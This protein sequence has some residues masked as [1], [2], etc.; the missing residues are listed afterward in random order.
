MRILFAISSLSLGGSERVALSLCNHWSNRSHQ[1]TLVTVASTESD[2]YSAEPQITRIALG[3]DRASPN[4][5][6]FLRNN[7]RRIGSL[8]SVISS[9]AP[10]V[11][12]SFGDTTNVLAILAG[13]GRG[14]PLIVS[15]RTDPRAR[16]VGRVVRLL[17]PMLYRRARAV[18]VQ[19]NSCAD[20]ARS[21]VPHQV[22]HVIPN[23][24]FALGLSVFNR[25]ATRERR[26]VLTLGRMNSEKGFDLLL[27]AFARCAQ[28]HQQW[29]LRIVGDGPER[30][31]LRILAEDLRI[32]KRTRLDG[33]TQSPLTPLREAALF[34]LPSRREGFP[35]VLL[36]AMACG[37]P[38]VSFDCLSGPNEIITH[39]QNG[40]LAPAG[41]VEGLA[42][43]M[44]RLMSSESLREQ[45]AANA[46]E[47]VDRYSPKRI[48]GMWDSL[49]AGVTEQNPV[50]IR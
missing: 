24:V 34:V 8:R 11:A 16:E 1:V 33:P 27:R 3:L 10:D 22:V 9:V 15:E 17:R 40:L 13:L 43:A 28:R 21:I 4:T 42:A 46:V 7:A 50:A 30:P 18:V 31:R 12:V 32:A 23:P 44:D 49:V 2:F 48:F 37:L 25:A 6:Q 20:W 29:D 41:D 26:T 35:N 38:V 45:L 47:V 5:I 19:T 36:E 39:G 14:L